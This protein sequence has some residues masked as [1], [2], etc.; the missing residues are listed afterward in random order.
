MSESQEIEICRQ[1]DPKIQKEYGGL[2]PDNDL[3]EFMQ[4]GRGKWGKSRKGNLCERYLVSTSY[5]S[6]LNSPILSD[7]V[8][9]TQVLFD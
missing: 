2:Y 1:M 8:S 4:R 6:P 5:T 7:T 3:Q 9:D